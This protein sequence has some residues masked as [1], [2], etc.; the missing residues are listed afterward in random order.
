MGKP[1]EYLVK[2]KNKAIRKRMRSDGEAFRH[3][4][5]A[6]KRR[7][8]AGTRRLCEGM[9]YTLPTP[10]DPFN[11][12]GERRKRHR[13]TKKKVP[14]VAPEHL[15]LSLEVSNSVPGT[16]HTSQQRENSLDE[17]LLNDE[18]KGHA[19]RN[20]EHLQTV[21]GVEKIT[22]DT[23]MGTLN[24]LR[25]GHEKFSLQKAKNGHGF[26]SLKLSKNT[27]N[28]AFQPKSCSAHSSLKDCL[29]LHTITTPGDITFE[30]VTDMTSSM[31]LAFALAR[32]LKIISNRQKTPELELGEAACENKIGSL[33]HEQCW[34][35]CKTGFN[36]LGSCRDAVQRILSYV[37]AAMLHIAKKDLLLSSDK[38]PIILFLVTSPEEALHVRKYCRALK[39]TWNIQSVSLHA[40]TEIERQIEGLNSK[41]PELIVATPDRLSDLVKLNIISLANI[42]L[43]VVD[44]L[45]DMIIDGFAEQLSF[46]QSKLRVEPQTFV[47]SGS[48]PIGTVKAIQCLLRDPVLRVAYEKSMHHQSACISQIV[49][50]VVSND[51]RLP[52]LCKILKHNLEKKGGLSENIA[53]TL[54]LVQAKEVAYDILKAVKHEGL[55]VEVLVSDQKENLL[56]M[57]AVLE[58]LRTGE[59]QVLILNGVVTNVD[60]SRIQNIVNYDFPPSVHHYRDILTRMARFSAYGELHSLC[61]GSM[62]HLA[63]ELIE[64]LHDCY[65]PIPKVLQMLAD[66]Y[67]CLHQK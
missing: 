60:L 2:K 48:Y 38:N 17:V 50:V 62:A 5:E 10:E 31:S 29:A 32:N 11:E 58:S 27:T 66:A 49:T 18:S 30:A 25:K 13:K 9:C 34:K 40:G 42:S 61:T 41:M 64:L 15:Q 43:L 53:G 21:S 28:T 26:S 14:P 37:P 35:A 3:G 45:E 44:S 4:V 52:K 63:S 6:S 65:Q 7:R 8:K 23:I 67:F 55:S 54:V 57:E 1:D 22:A 24:I 20:S 46:I 39:M 59:L 47:F 33:F 12:R 16:V 56:S 19:Q 51:K 36:V